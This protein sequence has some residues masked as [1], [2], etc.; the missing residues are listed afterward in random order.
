MAGIELRIQSCARKMEKRW[1]EQAPFGS[2]CM[3]VGRREG[4]CVRLCA[5]VLM[6]RGGGEGGA[7]V[8][9]WAMVGSRQCTLL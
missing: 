6:T 8:I 2:A 1:F 3:R 5:L 9:V 4:I 7:V